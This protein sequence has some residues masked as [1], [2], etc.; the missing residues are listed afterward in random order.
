MKKVVLKFLDFVFPFFNSTKKVEGIIPFRFFRQIQDFEN[1]VYYLF[2]RLT[3]YIFNTGLFLILVTFLDLALGSEL[4]VVFRD[5]EAYPAELLLS[6]LN[7]FAAAQIIITILFYLKFKLSVD[8]QS[9]D[10]LPV[11]V[12]STRYWNKKRTWVRLYLISLFLF[13]G[14]LCGQFFLARHFMASFEVEYSIFGVIFFM[15]LT[16]LLLSFILSI[17]I[18]AFIFLEKII[19]FFPEAMRSIEEARKNTQTK[20]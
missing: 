7:I 15:F 19:R 8:L 16:V 13:G 20:I 10:I 18:H 12:E 9:Y 17:F 3:L 6:F 2:Y 5:V 1:D 11:S 14:F 4:I